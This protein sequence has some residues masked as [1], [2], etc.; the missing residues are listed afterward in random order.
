M[1][2]RAKIMNAAARIASVV[3]ALDLE[4]S[5]LET[6]DAMICAIVLVCAPEI[7]GRVVAQTLRDMAT[8]LD[9]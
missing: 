8:A 3:R 7:P 9:G 4:T 5:T 6:V 2:D 1:T